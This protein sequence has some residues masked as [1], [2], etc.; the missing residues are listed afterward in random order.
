MLSGR[1]RFVLAESAKNHVCNSSLKNGKDLIVRLPN[2]NL[3]TQWFYFYLV[4]HQLRLF[5]KTQH[6]KGKMKKQINWGYFR[7]G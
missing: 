3:E 2:A 7:N 4:I 5:E 6:L 1:F